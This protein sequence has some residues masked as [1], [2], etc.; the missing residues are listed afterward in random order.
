[1]TL[2]EIETV[3]IGVSTGDDLSTGTP[4][5]KTIPADQGFYNA[6]PLNVQVDPGIGFFPFGAEPRQFDQFYIASKEAFSKREAAAVLTFDLDL[7]TL[8]APS[9]VNAGS[10]LRA[11]SIGLR[12]RLY[13]LDLNGGTFNVLGNPSE[14]KGSPFLPTAHSAPSSITNDTGGIFV[15]V[16]TEDSLAA[17]N[18]ANKIWVNFHTS[19]Q[20]T[21]TWTD[22]EAPGATPTIRLRFSPAIVRT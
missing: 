11:Y 17:D 22:L 12:H 18:P 8:A 7:Q 4:V 14:S 10:G 5:A 13:E 19:S 21:G 3:K 15:V 6:T 16:N 9:V 2:P 1:M 20:T